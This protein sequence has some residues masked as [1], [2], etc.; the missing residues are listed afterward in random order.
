MKTK[1]Y[2]TLLF[3]SLFF[4]KTQ[5]QC[6]DNIK[7]TS[8]EQVDAFPATYGCSEIRYVLELT[9]IADLTNVDSLYQLTRVGTLI[10]S[11][12]PQLQSLHGF[13]NLVELQNL[14]VNDNDVLRDLEGLGSLHTVTDQ[15]NINA[16]LNMQSLH[17]LEGLR[18]VNTLRLSYLTMPDLEPLSGL[19]S[20]SGFFAIA[21]SNLGSLHGLENLV[22]IG[23]AFTIVG[24]PTLTSLDG[25]SSLN[26]AGSIDL[27]D[28]AS[29]ADVAMPALQSTGMIRIAN[30]D[31]LTNISG[32]PSLTSVANLEIT[33]NATLA[34]LEGFSNVTTMSGESGLVLNDNPQLASLEGLGGISEITGMVRITR[35]HMLTSLTGLAVT[36]TGQLGITENENLVDLR[37]LENLVSSHG[38]GGYCNCVSPGLYILENPKLETIDQLSSLQFVTPHL[39]VSGNPLLTHLDGL[40]SLSSVGKMIEISNNASLRNIDGLSAL[41]TVGRNTDFGD[42]SVSIYQ[43]PSLQSIAG[44]KNLPVMPGGLWIADNDS[45][46]SLDGLEKITTIGNSLGIADNAMLTD[47]DALSKVT[48]VRGFIT[49]SNNAA[50]PNLNGLGSLVSNDS[51]GP[52]SYLKIMNNQSLTNV[53]SLSGLISMSA[54]LKE[55]TV[56]NNPNLVRG[57][58][59]YPLIVNSFDCTPCNPTLVISGNGPDVTEEGIRHGGP[60]EGVDP[61]FT[62]TQPTELVFSQ[63]SNN[64]M[65]VSFSP[66]TSPASGGYLVVMRAYEAVPDIAPADGTSYSVGNVIGGSMIVVGVGHDTTHHVIYLEP[67]TPYYFA[68]W[69]FSDGLDYLTINPLAGQ[70]ST[71]EEGTPSMDLVFSNITENSMSVSFTPHDT[72]SGFIT[73]MQAFGSGLPGDAPQNG[74]AYQ[75]GNVIGSSTIVVGFGTATTLNIIYLEPNVNYYFNVIG[76]SV[77]DGAY[78]YDVDHALSGHQRTSASPAVF[79][80]AVSTPYPNPFVEDVTIPFAVSNDTMVKIVISDQLGRIV[81]EIA[82]SHYGPGN[83]EARWD[84]TDLYGNRVNGGLYM[85]TIKTGEGKSAIQGRLMAK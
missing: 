55:L 40:S 57:C 35:N 28:N 39:V 2:L 25:L 45:L 83:H 13:S 31:A 6:P 56:T 78:Q 42:Q 37:G 48:S 38:G 27:Q 53:D 11:N 65:R 32:L 68:V 21:Y 43:N 58:G 63:V 23:R 16:H 74:S 36:K 18:S 54:P 69:S 1:F 15:I 12:N 66:A 44:L 79:A 70:Q 47:I 67:G 20:I 33:G 51:G 50:L 77:V 62:P 59:L 73:L 49:I 22:S 82:S 80:A 19:D 8:Q 3:T 81:S 17:G 41:K 61:P 26:H 64:S 71:G 60:C 14:F 76:Y 30:N 9:D 10:I 46:M 4:F 5:A 52:D 29:L 85:Y 24:V 84:R 34:S 72:S 75:V 7:L